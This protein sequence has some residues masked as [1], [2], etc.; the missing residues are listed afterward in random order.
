M[1]NLWRSRKVKNAVA[2]LLVLYYACAS[3]QQYSASPPAPLSAE[4]KITSFSKENNLNPT[5]CKRQAD[6]KI[7]LWQVNHVWQIVSLWTFDE[8]KIITKCISLKKEQQVLTKIVL[9]PHLEKL[10][11]FHNWHVHKFT[12]LGM[13]THNQ[14]FPFL[15]TTPYTKCECLCNS[16][17]LHQPLHDNH[18][19]L[20]RKSNKV[21]T[22]VV[23]LGKA[24]LLS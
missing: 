8:Q 14:A 18:M 3:T 1:L 24:F 16:S 2:C 10:S 9:F 22:N 6:W 12:C 11:Y 15:H 7:D 4:S 17:K 23:L 5:W 13:S 19:Y 21:L 20:W